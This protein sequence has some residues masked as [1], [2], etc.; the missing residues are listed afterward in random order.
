MV[1]QIISVPMLHL[2]LVRHTHFQVVMVFILVIIYLVVFG[3]YLEKINF[4]F[5]V[6]CVILSLLLLLMVII[7]SLLLFRVLDIIR[8]RLPVRRLNLN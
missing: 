1:V 2:T 5:V 8:R 7:I 6:F 3:L 4:G